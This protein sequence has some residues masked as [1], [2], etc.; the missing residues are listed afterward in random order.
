MTEQ[1]LRILQVSTYDNRGGAA[2]VAWH[3]HQAYRQQGLPARMVVG[4]KFSHDPCVALVSNDEVKSRFT[5]TLLKLSHS[6]PGQNHCSR[7]A[8]RL[9]SGL[10]WLAEPR[11][12][13]DIRKGFEDFHYPGTW[14]L[15][16]SFPERVTIIH[17]HN[18]HGGYFDLRALPWLSRQAPLL[19]TLHDAWMLS[20]HCAHSFACDRWKTGCG[21]CPDLTIYPAIRRDATALNWKR[22]QDIYARSRLY[23]ATPSQWLMD[24]VQQSILMEGV[25][26]CRVI[27]NGV[28]LSVF[29]PADK[30]AVRAALGIP[31]NVKVALIAANAIRHSA[32]KDAQTV[33]A[34]LSQ[35]SERWPEQDV[36]FIALGEDAP[37]QRVGQANVHFVPYQEDPETVA[38]Y[39]Q[40]AD[41]Y[42]HP[43]R[44]DTFPNT[45]I[46]AL[47][48]G[49][50]V[51][52]TAVGGIPEQVKSVNILENDIRSRNLRS[53]GMDEATGVLVQERDAKAM[54]QAMVLLL[55]DEAV[56]Q[57]LGQNAARDARHRF[58]LAHQVEEY[59]SWYQE[60]AELW[61]RKHSASQPI[62]EKR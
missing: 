43:A 11:R 48:C 59:L 37:P 54:A 18:L 27:P 55:T 39:Y 3:L 36:R 26:E 12:Q 45:V 32:W 52:A 40:A 29:R 13:Y 2:L 21:H 1:P 24:R 4:E 61:N 47:A 30:Q 9:S 8:S 20:G 38:R 33:L 19:L 49:T 35:I 53:Y 25:V 57:R 14:R 58:S 44:A 34:A 31:A 46:E 16:E 6:L 28:D 5:Q 15:L 7:S 23:I 50:P 22:K 51:V 56:C 42:V 62:Y 60:I 10:R 17:G 41:V